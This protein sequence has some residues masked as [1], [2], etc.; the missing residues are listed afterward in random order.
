AADA[1]RR[2]SRVVA[3]SLWPGSLVAHSSSMVTLRLPMLAVLRSV[4]FALLYMRRR[5][6]RLASA[7]YILA[8][9]RTINRTSGSPLRVFAGCC[10]STRQFTSQTY[11]STCFIA[12]S[13]FVLQCS[14]PFGN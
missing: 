2:D 10:H 14:L 12:D 11:P 1:Y 5:P 4:A 6:K 7:D 9:R 3:V 13:R 8:R